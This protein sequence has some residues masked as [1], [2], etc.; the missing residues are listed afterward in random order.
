MLIGRRYA[1]V[2]PH[3]HGV[4]AAGPAPLNDTVRRQMKAMPR[5]NTG[6]EL[7]LRRELHRRGLRFRVHIRNLPGTPD[8]A[9]TKARLAVFVDGCFWHRCPDHGTS[10]K[11]NSAWWAAKLDG[12]VRRDRRKDEEL[13]E[14]GWLS[15]HVW[16][17]EDVDSAAD[18]IEEIWRYRTGRSAGQA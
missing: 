5:R 13:V 10:P 16:E 17:H 14:L 7:A 2:K 12:N 18:R 9:F 1:Q 3:L 6:V 11:N 8:V 4:R 15:L